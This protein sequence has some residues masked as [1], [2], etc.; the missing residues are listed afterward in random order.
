MGVLR[1]VQQQLVGTDVPPCE[2]HRR[3]PVHIGQQ[4]QAETL[5]VGGVGETVHSHGGLRGV[6]RLPDTLVQLIVRD[7]AP[8]GWLT[9]GDG[10]QVCRC[11]AQGSKWV[12]DH[13]GP[14]TPWML[15]PDCLP[16]S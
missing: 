14:C 4:P 11:R 16:P 3:I 8:E 6:E 13:L 15:I 9:V 12:K 10:L 1:G 7:G 5:R 2:L